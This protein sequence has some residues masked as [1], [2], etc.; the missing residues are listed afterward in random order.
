MIHQA[1]GIVVSGGPAPGINSVIS[2]IVIAACNRGITPYGLQDGFA[3]VAAQGSA[4]VRQL[5]IGEVSTI[6]STGG[7]ILGTS[8]C[9][10]LTREGNREQF[11]A[12][13]RDKS[14]TALIVIGGDGSAF[15]SAQ[16]SQEFPDLAV[17]HVP[18]TIDND[19]VLPNHHPSFGF[20]T[21]RH[22]SQEILNTLMVDARTTNRW[23]LVTTMGRS[24]GYLALG[25]GIAAGVTLTLI[26]EEFAEERKTPQQMAKIIFSTLEKRTAMGRPYGVILC[27][28]GVAE[29]LDL[30][31]SSQDSSLP[32]DH[33][34]R[35]KFSDIDLGDLLLDPLRTLC[36]S[37]E[38]KTQIT[39][40][41]IGY[42]LRCRPPIAFDVEYTRFLGF[43]AVELLSVGERSCMVVRDFDRLS[44][45]PLSELADANGRIRR[46]RVDIHSDLYRVA[47]SF[48]IR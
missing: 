44:S 33:M 26:P 15:L 28:E 20:E 35:P 48:M 38:L 21:A 6:H 19:L 37:S 4:A 7:S 24:A 14:I 34:G 27:A 25:A 10:P 39:A 2:S 16:L 42:E 23:F 43:G 11:T 22:A 40:K 17:L 45:R 47:R 32:V 46:R 36:E 13:L 31:H 1:I 3:G 18:K 41:N 5:S 9:N 29:C 12:A 30:S 8:R